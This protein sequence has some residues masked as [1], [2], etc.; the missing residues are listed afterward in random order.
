MIYRSL[1]RWLKEIGAAFHP[2]ARRREVASEEKAQS[3]RCG[4][5]PFRNR[6]GG[7]EEEP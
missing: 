2:S 1:W 4:I 7:G 6:S 5:V 3:W